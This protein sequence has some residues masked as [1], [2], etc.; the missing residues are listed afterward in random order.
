M[1]ERQRAGGSWERGETERQMEEEWKLWYPA[2]LSESEVGILMIFMMMMMMFI[3]LFF[4]DVLF[5]AGNHFQIAPIP[6]C[7]CS[8]L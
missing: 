7:T 8:H 1:R 5:F 6:G 3:I 2:V 4:F